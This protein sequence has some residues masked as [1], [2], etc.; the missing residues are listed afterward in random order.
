MTQLLLFLLAC[1]RF[2]RWNEGT[3]DVDLMLMIVMFLRN[4]IS[5]LIFDTISAANHWKLKWSL[6]LSALSSN[7][8]ILDV[9]GD[10]DDELCCVFS[11]WWIESRLKC[12]R[13]HRD[14]HNFIHSLEIYVLLSLLCAQQFNDAIYSFLLNYHYY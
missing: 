7:L 13:L 12:L 9:R 5:S 1:Q 14:A 2:C 6:L 8:H 10:N 3:Q 4:R 11:F